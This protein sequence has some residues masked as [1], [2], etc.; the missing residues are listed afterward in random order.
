MRTL[1]VCWMTVIFLSRATPVDAQSPVDAANHPC[2]A[3]KSIATKRVKDM[4]IWLVNEPGKFAAGNNAFC[5]EFR[6]SDAAGA[7]DVRSVKVDFSLL[8]GRIHEEPISA[9]IARET[10]GIYSG[11]V[12]LGRQ[13]YN[14]ALYYAVVHYL[15]LA[16]KKRNTRFHLAVK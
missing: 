13:Y 2:V 1:T 14:P 6:T 5:I 10:V 11:S 12:N 9:L 8:V 7:V 16:G 4:E 3:G 15:D